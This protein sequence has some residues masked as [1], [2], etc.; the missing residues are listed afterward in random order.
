MRNLVAM[1]PTLVGLVRHQSR[2]TLISAMSWLAVER[3]P[4][5]IRR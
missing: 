1:T 2:K 3:N 5:S 4:A